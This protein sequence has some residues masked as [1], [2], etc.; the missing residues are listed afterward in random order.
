V[1]F[2]FMADDLPVSFDCR[3]PAPVVGGLLYHR[4]LLPAGIVRLLNRQELNAALLHEVAQRAHGKALVRALAKLAIPEEAGFLQATGS[5]F[6][7][8]GSLEC[9]WH[10]IAS[11]PAT[12]PSLGR[13]GSR[14]G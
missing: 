5:S 9:G 1:T 6:P 11:F 14:A 4:I 13:S 7:S 10:S 8:S 3:H 12:E 2:S